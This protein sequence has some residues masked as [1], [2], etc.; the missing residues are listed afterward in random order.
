MAPE[1][2]AGAGM[3][4]LG[5]EAGSKTLEGLGSGMGAA[6]GP[7]GSSYVP[8]H[9]RKG[10]AGSGERMGGKYERDDLATLRVTNVCPPLVD[11]VHL[12]CLINK[13]NRRSANL[14]KKTSSAL[15]SNVSVAS[16]VSSLQKIGRLAG[17]RASPLCLLSTVLTLQSLAKRWT[18]LV[19]VT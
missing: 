12:S 13:T 14:P 2:E 6:S 9:M 19:T 3:A 16:L 4:D 11:I 10:G 15:F 7:G 1:G 8:P 5:E 18:A 17:Q